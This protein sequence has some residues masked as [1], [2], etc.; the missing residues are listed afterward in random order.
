MCARFPQFFSSF[1]LK[2]AL[3]YGVVSLCF[4]SF[5]LTKEGVFSF[6]V[7]AETADFAK[8]IKYW[9]L[10]DNLWIR[11]YRISKLLRYCSKPEVLWNWW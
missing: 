3:N 10:M 11:M 4:F 2:Y 9:R 6:Y 7:G 8:V 5:G 1:G